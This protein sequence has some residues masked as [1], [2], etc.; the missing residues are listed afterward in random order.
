[1]WQ[2]KLLAL[3]PGGQIGVILTAIV[4][5]IFK[6]IAL[7]VSFVKWLVIDITDAFK[8]P[9]R[10]LVRA[11]CIVVVLIFGLMAGINHKAR[12]DA[13]LITKLTSERDAAVSE[14]NDWRQRHANEEQR[15]A[16][17]AEARDKA[18]RRVLELE[19]PPQPAAAPPAPVQRLRP[20]PAAAVTPQAPVFSLQSIFGVSK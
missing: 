7:A 11:V 2:F 20:R 6:L 13:A 8:E 9:Q 3:L 14:R 1:M 16:D 15:A 18:Q 12:K 17:A 5:V 19:K 4:N 10:L